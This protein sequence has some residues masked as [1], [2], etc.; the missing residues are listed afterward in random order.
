MQLKHLILLALASLIAATF[1]FGNAET[2][3]SIPC[4]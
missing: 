3:V 4:P 2:T 1:D